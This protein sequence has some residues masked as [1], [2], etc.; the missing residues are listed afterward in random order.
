LTSLKVFGR[1][2]N[3]ADGGQADAAPKRRPLDAR[4]HR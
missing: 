3:I 2:G 1:N 4:D